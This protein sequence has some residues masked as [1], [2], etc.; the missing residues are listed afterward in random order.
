MET[1][2]ERVSI[3]GEIVHE[4]LLEIFDHVRK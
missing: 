4:D 2:V 3:D 1:L